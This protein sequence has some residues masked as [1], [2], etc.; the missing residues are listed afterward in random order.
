MNMFSSDN[1]DKMA[2]RTAYEAAVSK[3]NRDDYHEEMFINKFVLMLM[4]DI[5]PN[6]NKKYFWKIVC[7]DGSVEHV[8]NFTYRKPTLNEFKIMVEKLK[9][10]DQ[11]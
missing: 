1:M 6:E 3:C 2:N 10:G 9:A 11:S 5:E 7:P 8:M 4:E